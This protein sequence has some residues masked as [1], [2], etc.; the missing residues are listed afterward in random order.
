MYVKFLTEYVEINVYVFY[1]IYSDNNLFR[2]LLPHKSTL[3][4]TLRIKKR[5]EKV[6]RT[7]KTTTVWN[8]KKYIPITTHT[9]L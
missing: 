5:K 4:E 7:I 1:C 8:I 6:I 3:M 2:L 9:H